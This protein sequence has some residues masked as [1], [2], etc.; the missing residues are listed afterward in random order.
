MVNKEK[1]MKVCPTCDGSGSAI[2]ADND[3]IDCPTCS[4][5]GFIYVEETE[6]GE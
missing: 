5:D 3:I 4:G 2:D 1:E 6:G